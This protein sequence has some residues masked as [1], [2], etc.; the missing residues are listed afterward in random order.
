MGEEKLKYANLS[1]EEVEELL[2]KR[3][4]EM[5]EL[6]REIRDLLKSIG[7]ER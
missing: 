5:K 6:L 1:D 3:L 4:R 7:G 2:L